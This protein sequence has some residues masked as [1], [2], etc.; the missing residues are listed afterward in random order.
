MDWLEEKTEKLRVYI[1]NLSFRKAMVAY[2]LVISA[3]VWGLSYLTMVFCWHWEIGIWER[4]GKT[5]SLPLIVY[6]KGLLW[7]YQHD[8]LYTAEERSLLCLDF[9][10]VW[11]PLIYAVPGMILAIFL[12]YRKRLAR[13]L[14]I[15]EDSVEKIRRNDLDFHVS[16]DSRDELG[17]L[18]DSVE[19]MRLEL[20]RD[21]EEMWRLME[22]QKEL[23]AAFA[24]D[25][26][27]PLTVL[28][29][30]TDF[31]ARYIPEGKISREKLQS[32]LGLMAEHLK[33]LEDYSRT[34]KGIRSIEEVPFSPEKTTFQSMGRK[35][36]EV[37]FALNQVR[38]VKI[39]YTADLPHQGYLAGE[40]HPA[41]SGGSGAEQQPDAFIYRNNS[42]AAEQRFDSSIY[43]AGSLAAEQRSEAS[44]YIDDG[45]VMEVLENM[46]S[47]AIR[48]A[49]KQINV[50][51]DYDADSRE[52]ILTVR[53]D[54]PGFSE[55]Q[56]DKALKPYYKETE[57]GGPDEH[58]GIGL[59]ICRELCKKHGGT[60]NVAN[61]IRGG[62]V[63]T[64]SFLAGAP[65]E[66]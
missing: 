1:R 56:M 26:R 42:L 62:A 48:Y 27:T 17:M 63:V 58:F 59:H 21:K 8:F 12:F 24:H 22:R 44:I 55:E 3:A 29:G 66:P 53:D 47:N 40:M 4:L 57:D 6:Q 33:R 36:E 18:C 19:T 43:P 30:Y 32:T 65:A 54:G 34:M 15:L 11:C 5:E 13:P 50:M 38:D 51:S 28:R 64:A 39:I 25:L 52:W 35:I 46:L 10:R 37:V 60:L 16:Y 49:G 14:S 9:L 61:S 41:G 2:I 7:S 45:L 31:L 20:L 23:N